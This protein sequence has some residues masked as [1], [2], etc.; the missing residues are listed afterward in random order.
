MNLLLIIDS[1]TRGGRE[2]RLIALLKALSVDSEL[3]ITLVVLSDII[4][5]PE[6]YDMDIAVHSIKRNPKKDPRVF[7]KLFRIAKKTR[8][9]LI[10][11]WGSM[12]T[13]YAIPACLWYRIPLINGSIANAP[14][15]QRFFDKEYLQS[16]VTFPFSNKIVSNSKAGLTSYKAPTDKSI[17]I[18][19]GFDPL[20]LKNLQRMQYIR[21]K[22][23][24][25]SGKIVGM[26]GEF[27]DRKDYDSYLKA[28]SILLN[29]GYQVSF[30]GLGEGP[31]LTKYRSMIPLPHRKRILFPGRISD[32]ESMVNTFDIG[33]L[34][35]N[36]DVHG[37]G[38][39]NSIMEYMAFAK[40]VVATDG[41]GTR[42]IVSDAKSGFLVR[43]KS[44]TLLAEKV[45]YLL[46]N[47]DVAQ[48]MGEMGKKI[49]KDEFSIKKMELSYR[50]L[51]VSVAKTMPT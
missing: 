15:R 42:E 34:S 31:N 4:L 22:Y 7:L 29:D 35:T 6:V 46:D 38:I 11:T 39:S 1:L 17:C 20:R 28:A 50:K 33:V 8:P 19:N 24:I 30:L 9:A 40:P 10:H 25:E 45:K 47:P 36:S 14:V 49:V 43:S 27:Y 48:R 13:I 16:K 5:Y 37:E 3:R 2:R 51:Y 21:D 44:P 18:P 23:G 26:V 12:S 41:G 32:I